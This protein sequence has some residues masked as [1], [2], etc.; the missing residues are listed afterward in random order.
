[1]RPLIQSARSHA[2]K[3]AATAAVPPSAIAPPCWSLLVA[4]DKS[5]RKQECCTHFL[6]GFLAEFL[7]VSRA[8]AWD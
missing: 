5:D 2:G 7:W 6:E 3:A 4:H 8:L 1:M